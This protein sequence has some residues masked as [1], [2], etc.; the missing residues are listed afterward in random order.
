MWIAQALRCAHVL[1]TFKSTIVDSRIF[2]LSPPSSI[3]FFWGGENTHSLTILQGW[4]FADHWLQVFKDYSL[5]RLSV[6]PLLFAP[7]GG[8]WA[9][10]FSGFFGMFFWGD[11]LIW[12]FFSGKKW[13]QRKFQLT[14][15]HTRQGL[16]KIMTCLDIF[17]NS[18]FTNL[19]LVWC[20]FVGGLWWPRFC[21]PPSFWQ[22]FTVRLLVQLL[23]HLLSLWEQKELKFH[24]SPTEI[25]PLIV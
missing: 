6:Y 23:R 19:S 22:C 16:T 15:W 4:H 13:A 7:H 9:A 12:W 14:L 17:G 20:F 18:N 1:W 8:T 11:L 21:W 3:P 5:H 2:C 10:T 25:F 24:T